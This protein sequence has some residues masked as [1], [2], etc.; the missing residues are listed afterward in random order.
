MSEE[1]KAVVRRAFDEIAQG[2]LDVADEIIAP[3]YVRHDLAGGPDADG[4][5]GAEGLVAGR[6]PGRAPAPS[7]G[8]RRTDSAPPGAVPA[9]PPPKG[10]A[11]ETRKP[12]SSRAPTMG[13]RTP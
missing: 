12:V 1:N 10:G 9:P 3:E 8:P 6:G 7:S 11:M 2:N 4:A 5:D 13:T